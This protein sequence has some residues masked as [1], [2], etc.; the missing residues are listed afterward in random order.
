MH[1]RATTVGAGPKTT[2]RLATRGA[3]RVWSCQAGWPQVASTDGTRLRRG[4]PTTPA[5]RV[6]ASF[7]LV[8]K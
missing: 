5:N 1:R 4:S 8:R 3:T 2:Q 6:K 7:T